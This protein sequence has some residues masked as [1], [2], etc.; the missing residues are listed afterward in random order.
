VLA[1]LPNIIDKKGRSENMS[2]NI[3]LCG[4]GGQ[5]LVLLTNVIGNAC[6]KSGKRAITGELHGLGQRSGTV[7]AHLRIGED[8][9]SPLIPYGEADILVALEAIESLRYIEFLK[10][11]GIV[12]MN[13]RIIHPPVETSKIITHKDTKYITINDIVAKLRSWTTNIAVVDA[14][15]LARESGNMNTENTVLLGFLSALK[16][17]PVEETYIKE[18]IAE[19]VPKKTIKPNM[20]AFELGKKSAQLASI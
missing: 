9:F 1:A 7:F 2:F 4:V 15:Q 11:N 16:A 6:T 20:K 19:A 8:A 13:K 14:Q 18:S 3:F 5:G 17:F 10:K 12:L